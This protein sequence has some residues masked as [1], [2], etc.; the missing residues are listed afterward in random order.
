MCR[1]CFQLNC[2]VRIVVGISLLEISK[3]AWMRFNDFCRFA[4]DFFFSSISHIH[5]IQITP[6]TQKCIYQFVK[7]IVYQIIHL[8][9]PCMMYIRERIQNT[10]KNC[11]P[12]AREELFRPINCTNFSTNSNQSSRNCLLNNY[13]K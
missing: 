5:C 7:T 11:L 10:A 12:E 8:D 9:I 6:C 3:Q 13:L 4:L 1:Y 2:L